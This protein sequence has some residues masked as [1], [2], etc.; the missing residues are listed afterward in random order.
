MSGTI[1]PKQDNVLLQII[2][3]EISPGGL[4]I[5]EKARG[6]QRDAAM[7]RVLAVGPGR[8]TEFGILITVDVEPGQFVLIPRN[9]GVHVE[10]ERASLRVIRCG[11]ILCGVT[12][13]EERRI[14]TPGA[15]S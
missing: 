4:I 10:H 11:E 1:V 2:E 13:I 12:E 8:T 6:N 7:G 3:Q 15:P 9:A 14:I 5:P